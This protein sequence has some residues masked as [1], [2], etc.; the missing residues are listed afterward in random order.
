MR[1]KI[2]ILI[3]TNRP[4]ENFAKRVVDGL[5]SQDMSENDNNEAIEINLQLSN[6]QH[7]MPRYINNSFKEECR[8]IL[9]NLI[10]SYIPGE[11][12][13]SV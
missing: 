10:S 9:L 2:S 6:F 5:F 4:Y 7:E 3:S 1:S 8:E 11:S 13:L 12:Y